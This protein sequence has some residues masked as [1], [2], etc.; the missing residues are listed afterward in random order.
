MLDL[1]CELFKV[2]FFELF[3]DDFKLTFVL[4]LLLLL[5]YVQSV[6]ILEGI[7]GATVEVLH[8]L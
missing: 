6:S 8:Y 1:S 3:L 4:V 5:V 7:L 2:V